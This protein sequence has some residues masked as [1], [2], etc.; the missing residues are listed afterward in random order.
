MMK[1][2]IV[3]D[4]EFK[5]EELK[6]ELSKYNIEYFI[7]SNLCEALMYSHKYKSELCGIISD[8]GFTESELDFNINNLQN[9]VSSQNQ[10]ENEEEN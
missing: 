3:E 6:K 8:L 10:V 4:S 1:L 9:F 2:L 5:V 7:A